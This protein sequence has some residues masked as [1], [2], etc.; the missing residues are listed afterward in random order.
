MLTANMPT[1]P[2]VLNSF[3]LHTEQ[4]SF[5]LVSHSRKIQGLVEF[6]NN[7]KSRNTSTVHL[8]H[9]FFIHKYL[10]E[11][12]LHVCNDMQAVITFRQMRGQ[13]GQSFQQI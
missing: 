4:Y 12:V 10:K 8:L 1:D 2:K 11:T 6:S 3:A 13:K 7:E 5:S 9:G